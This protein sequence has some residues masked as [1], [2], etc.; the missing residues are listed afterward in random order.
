MLFDIVESIS[1]SELFLTVDCIWNLHLLWFLSFYVEMCLLVLAKLQSQTSEWFECN[2]Q[3]GRRSIAIANAFGRLWV[4]LVFT[5]PSALSV[6]VGSRSETGPSHW[7]LKGW[8]G[9]AWLRSVNQSHFPLLISHIKQTLF[10]LQFY[11]R[12]RILVSRGH[13]RLSCSHRMCVPAGSLLTSGQGWF[14]HQV[15]VYQPLNVHILIRN[16]FL[17]VSGESILENRSICI[18]F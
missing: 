1:R 6:Y 17:S 18:E 12:L 2:G 11:L 9:G 5:A 15:V 13:K 14:W 16:C 7:L 8:E 4:F 3:S 10:C